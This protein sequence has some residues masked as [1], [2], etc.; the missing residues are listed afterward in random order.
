MG[1]PSR[2]RAP[3]R[4]VRDNP[5]L[6]TGPPP[7]P[8]EIVRGGDGSPPF[9]R[10]HREDFSREALNE[11]NLAWSWDSN[12]KDYIIIEK[13]LTRQEL[14]EL[15]QRAAW[16]RERKE[17]DLALSESREEVEQTQGL[18]QSTKRC[19]A[20][21]ANERR[22]EYDAERA[23]VCDDGS[24]IRG[25]ARVSQPGIHIHVDQ[26]QNNQPPVPRKASM[27]PSITELPLGS[28]NK[29]QRPRAPSTQ[30]RLSRPF[31]AH[32]F[33]PIEQPRQIPPQGHGS[34]SLSRTPR[35]PSELGV[36]SPRH[37]R[38]PF[39]PRPG[40]PSVRQGPRPFEDAPSIRPAGGRPSHL[41][42]PSED[43]QF[44]SPPHPRESYDPRPSTPS[45]QEGLRPF[46]GAPSM[47]PAG[48]RLSH[49]QP[50]FEDRDF[51]PPSRTESLA[52][53]RSE[54][55]RQAAANTR[56]FSLQHTRGSIRPPSQ[57][58]HFAPPSRTESLA[59][60]RSE[61][62]RQADAHAPAST[63]E[64]RDGMGR[65][66]SVRGFRANY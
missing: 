32:D 63:V 55:P 23:S 56:Q 61:R 12:D 48:R 52:G 1:Q 25:H 6:N 44:P 4:S 33:A 35:A 57:N 9:P 54:R 29:S 41:Q 3:S 21:R 16:L 28:L 58:V 49:I 20:G 40:L 46:A 26:T 30:S 45:V 15:I 13:H 62:P 42:P 8:R 60:A 47:R 5:R 24:H 22:H 64:G 14:K 17:R 2:T 53:A 27:A 66:N 10:V 11:S 31:D 37:G 39:A 51:A 65:R 50:P 34:R 43:V 59:G 36:R 38:E 18:R 7:S 19:D